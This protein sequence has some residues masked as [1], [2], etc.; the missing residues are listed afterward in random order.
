MTKLLKYKNNPQTPSVML[1]SWHWVFDVVLS[2]MKKT[3]KQN[4]SYLNPSRLINNKINKLH[5]STYKKNFKKNWQFC[6]ST[7]KELAISYNEIIYKV[8]NGSSPDLMK[9]AFSL[10][11]ASVLNPD[12]RSP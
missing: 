9:K 3:D 6:F 11:D 12:V 7:P 1:T 10:N 8:L 4:F 2:Q 5:K